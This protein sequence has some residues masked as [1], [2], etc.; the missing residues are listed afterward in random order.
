VVGGVGVNGNIFV[1]GVVTATTFVGNFTAANS[2]T[3]YVGF[4]VTATNIIGGSSGSI[5]Y[6][7]GSGLTTSLPVSATGGALLASSG[8]LPQYVTQVQAITGG[9]GSAT[10]AT[11]QTLVVTG[12]GLGVTGASYFANN[13]GFGGNVT[14]AGTLSLG[15][16]DTISATTASFG[17][18]Y[19]TTAS[20]SNPASQAVGISATTLDTFSTSTYR[21]AKY[22]I[23]VSNTYTGFYQA[24]EVLVV[25]DGVTPYL[26]DVSVATGAGNNSAPI[27]TFSTTITGGN[28][29]LQGTGTANTNTVKVSVVYVT[30]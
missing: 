5:L 20:V 29:L 9:T 8:S 6:Q 10:Q 11:G 3:M 1:G 23:S 14:I 27:V 25:H 26:Q 4:A 12:N 17:T 13:V 7:S 22:V 18:V 15:G 21:S 30:V 28:V 16:V 24:S 19:L 2:S